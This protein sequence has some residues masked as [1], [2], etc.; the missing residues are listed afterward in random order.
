MCGYRLPLHADSQV[1][2]FPD[3]IINPST[4][5]DQLH[6]AV[7]AGGSPGKRTYLYNC[8]TRQDNAAACPGITIRVEKLD[9]IVLDVIQRSVLAPDN[10]E[11]MLRDTLDQLADN[12]VDEIAAE[13][14]RLAAI[15]AELDRKIR[16]TATHAINGMI[17]ESDAK[18]ITAPL[19]AQ[20]DT[21][22]L[23]LAALPTRRHIPTIETIDPD[24][25]RNAVLEAWTARP[26]DERREALSSVVEK[27]ELSPG[28]VQIICRADGYH[29]HDP[30]GPPSVACARNGGWWACGAL[31][32]PAARR[33]P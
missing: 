30:F 2:R 31:R 29:G 20:R 21:A 22:R 33:C 10:V 17:D 14:D 18:A 9:Q 25:F 15:V 19:I 6:I 28:G 13:R 7:V 8:G 24:T 12:P 27:I 1:K 26:L 16:L 5:T 32:R 23:K 3:I 4:K 11:A